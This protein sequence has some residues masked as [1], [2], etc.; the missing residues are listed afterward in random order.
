MENRKIIYT[1]KITVPAMHYHNYKSI[2]LIRT[3]NFVN[4]AACNYFI[5]LCNKKNF[6]VSLLVK[7]EADPDVSYDMI[8]AEISQ[9]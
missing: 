6:T 1:V 5:S 4:E 9:V 3:F 7:Q 8:I 2:E